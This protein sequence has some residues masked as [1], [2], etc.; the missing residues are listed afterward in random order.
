MVFPFMHKIIDEYFP[1]VETNSYES[2]D[3]TVSEADFI[4]IVE[5]SIQTQLSSTPF[6]YCH[7]EKKPLLPL[8]SLTS[9]YE[10][11]FLVF[12]W[13]WKLKFSAT[14]STTAAINCVW[15]V[16]FVSDIVLLVGAFMLFSIL[17]SVSA[18]A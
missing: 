16:Y 1:S 15:C 18:V 8:P 3:L 12:H 7:Y 17:L 9:T 14:K 10:F 11:Y 13:K 6:C 5:S 4:S 2:L